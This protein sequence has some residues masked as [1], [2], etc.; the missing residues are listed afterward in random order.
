MNLKKFYHKNKPWDKNIPQNM[1]I[2]F[3][4]KYVRKCYFSKNRTAKKIKG[5]F[6]IIDV[7]NMNSLH[8]AT[9]KNKMCRNLE[10]QKP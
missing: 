3:V 6:C 5:A 4:E 10:Q 8:T 1:N 9:I 2:Y 7:L